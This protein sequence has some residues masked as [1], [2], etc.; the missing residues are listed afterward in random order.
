MTSKGSYFS[1]RRLPV[2]VLILALTASVVGAADTSKPKKV[3]MMTDM[4]GV[5]GIFSYELQC[6]PY[7]APR[8]KESL[9]LLTDEINAAVDGLLD[10]GA[11]EVVVCDSH[12]GGGILPLADIHPKARMMVGFHSKPSDLALDSSY[13]AIIFIGQHAMSGAENGILAHSNSRE[14]RGVWVNGIPVG[15]FGM[16]AFLGAGFGIPTVMVSGDTAMCREFFGLVP[17]GECAEVKS[18][19]NATAGIMLSHK[20]ACDLIHAKARRAMERL[21]EIKPYKLSDPVEIKI[22]LDHSL[23]DTSERGFLSRGAEQL[24]D[25]TFVFR[26]KDYLEAYKK[27]MGR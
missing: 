5:D 27:W 24:P 15:E 16:T 12:S 10:G 18:G 6:D 22:Q 1:V 4:E 26:G 2:A 21:P 11:T 20:D 17:N 9:K 14:W 3:F 19:F 8:W 23:G 13:S 7:K 25:W